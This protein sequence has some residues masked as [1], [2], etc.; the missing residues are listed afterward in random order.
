[1]DADAARRRDEVLRA[2]F[3]GRDWDGPGEFTLKR[4]FVRQSIELLPELPYLIDDEWEVVPGHTQAGRGDLVLTDGCGTFA[5]VEVKL[6][7]G[8][9]FG[10]SA[11]NAGRARTKKRKK[12]VEQAL[13]YAAVLR[14]R[15]PAAVEVQAYTWTNE[16]GLRRLDQPAAVWDA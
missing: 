4:D 3:K 5:A 12:V 8:G 6:I 16:D 1:M 13:N 15:F 14:R 7:D 10:G 11:K 9:A 2:Y